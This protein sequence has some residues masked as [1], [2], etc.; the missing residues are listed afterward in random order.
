[1]QLN[2]TY[3]S[4]KQ[5]PGKVFIAIDTFWIINLDSRELPANSIWKE[6]RV[7][8]TVDEYKFPHVPPTL[9]ASPFNR[10]Y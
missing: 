1:M 7:S 5:E 3:L 4:F 9:A 2:H 8:S 10:G 6:I